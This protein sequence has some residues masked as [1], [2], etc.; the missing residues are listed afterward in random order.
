MKYKFKILNVTGLIIAPPWLFGRASVSNKEH[1]KLMI[2]PPKHL[3]L[4]YRTEEGVI[5]TLFSFFPMKT[6][7]RGKFL[8]NGS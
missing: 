8:L 2:Q 4:S 6:E 3:F 5:W 7:K 1:Q